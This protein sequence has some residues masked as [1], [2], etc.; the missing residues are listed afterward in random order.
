MWWMSDVNC[1]IKSRC[2]N[3]RGEHLPLFWWKANVRGLW[4]VNV[5]KCRASSMWRKY[6][7]VSYIA[8]S[9]LSY[10]LYFC[11]AGLSFL[12]KKA[13]GCQTFAPTVGGRHPWRWRKRPC[14]GRVERLDRGEP[15]EQPEI[16]SLYTH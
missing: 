8:K 3:W 1:E 11:C 12:E 14:P 13:R 4:P 15:E 6:L 9:S 10:A 5:V 16:S 7:T 2:L